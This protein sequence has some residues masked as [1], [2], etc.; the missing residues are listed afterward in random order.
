VEFKKWAKYIGVKHELSSA[1]MPESDGLSKQDVKTT[2]HLFKKCLQDG[3]NFRA[4]MTGVELAGIV[5]G[6]VW[7]PKHCY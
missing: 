4:A 1:H 6:K 2:K 3:S 5:P 7:G